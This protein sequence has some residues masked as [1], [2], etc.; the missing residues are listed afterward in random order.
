MK[1]RIILI[2]I[3]LYSTGGFSTLKSQ[4]IRNFPFDPYT[5]LKTWDYDQLLK[6]MGNGEEVLGRSNNQTY[7][8][9]LSYPT[10]LLGMKGKLEFNFARDSISRIQF[11]MEHPMRVTSADLAGKQMRDPTENPEYVMAIKRLD[12]IQKRDSISRDSVVRAISDILGTPI[13]NSRT[14][15]TEKNARH[16]AIWVQRGYTTLYKD[17]STYSEIVFSLSTVPLSI[18]GEFEIPAGTQILQKA[19]VNTRKLSWTA[20][21]LGHPQNAASMSFTDI[22]LYLEF[23]TGEKSLVSVPKNAISYLTSKIPAAFATGQRSLLILPRNAIGYLPV[24]TFED[25]D[26]DAI[27]E[28]WVQVPSDIKGYPARHLIYAVNFKEPNL[29]FD[30]DDLIPSGISLQNS[31][32]ISITFQ[33]GTNRVIEAGSSVTLSKQTDPIRPKGFKYLSTTKLNSDGSANFVGGIE[34]KASAGSSSP[35]IL[36]ITFKHASGGWETDQ[37]RFVSLN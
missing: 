27:P 13:S 31:N 26:G 35:G 8:A 1:T 30:T 20:S 16:A 4:E 21:L 9:G 7:L 32:R 24:M 17:Y 36:E 18:V 22:F 6:K 14:A 2:L 25:C 28:V 11:R 5:I 12:S 3:A 29:I 33:D 37:I 34:L 23:S 19:V 15:V 10:D